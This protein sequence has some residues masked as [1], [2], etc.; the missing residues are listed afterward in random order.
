MPGSTSTQ[1]R[2]NGGWR[3]AVQV[4]D[5]RP[6]GKI[7]QWLHKAN[8]FSQLHRLADAIENHVLL[9]PENFN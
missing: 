6:D 1:A 2:L 8:R 5:Q 3:A 4:G 9:E 7:E